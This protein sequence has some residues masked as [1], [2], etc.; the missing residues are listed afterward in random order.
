MTIQYPD[1]GAQ[2]AGLRHSVVLLDAGA[3][4]QPLDETVWLQAGCQLRRVRSL[5]ELGA[6]LQDPAAAWPDAVVLVSDAPDGLDAMVQALRTLAPGSGK[7]LALM[8]LS[9]RDDLSVRLA[10]ARAGIRAFLHLPVSAGQVRTALGQLAQDAGDE[11]LRVLVV[12]DDALMVDLHAAMLRSAGI[13]VQTLTQPLKLLETLDAFDPDVVVLDVYMPEAS[14]P[15]LAA[16]L[17]ERALQLGLDLPILFLSPE[18]DEQIQMQA[19]Q[20]GG[21][22]FLLKPVSAAHLVAAVT[23]RA[24]RARR[25]NQ[26]QRQLRYALH[27]R[28]REHQALDQHAIVSIADVHGNIVYAND[29]FC[30]ISGYDR[31]DLIGQNHRIVKSAEHAPQFYREIW[32]TI[33]AGRI[34]HGELCNRR[35]DGGLYWVESTIVPLLDESGLPH[36][37]VSIRTD[38]T[39]VKQDEAVLR[40]LVERTVA[41]SGDDFFQATVGGLAQSLGVRM[42]FVAVREPHDPGACRTL[43]LWDH[44]G[45]AENFSYPL[46]GAPCENVLAHGVSVY[47]DEVAQLFPQDRWLADNGF[48]SYVGI[49]LLDSHGALLG[50]MGILDEQPLADSDRIVTYLHLFAQR[51]AS[52]LERRHNDQMLQAH[53]E[54]LRRGQLF[55]NIGTWEWNIQTGEL[56]WTERIA[57]LFGYPQGDLET[58]YENFLK[59]V[60]PDDRQSVI[61]AVNACIERDVPYEIEHRV[62]W[63]DGTERWLLERGAVLRDAQGR[64]LQMLGVVQDID[65]RR[66]A[67]QALRESTQLLNEAQALAQVGSWR[68]D[69]AT[70]E[71]IWS[72]ELHRMYGSDPALPPPPYTEHHKLFTP[73]SWE[74]LAAALART[75]ESGIP[76]E[77]ELETVRHDGSS[78]W[79]WVRGERVHDE[80]GKVV[81]LRGMAQEITERKRAELALLESQSKLRGLFDLSPLGIALADL[82]G[83][84]LEFNEAFRVICGYPEE[85]LLALDYWALTP[86]KYEDSEKKQLATLHATGRYGPYE[87]EYRRKDGTL[88]PIRLNGLLIR[89]RLGN[90]AIWSIVEDIS[91]RKQVERDMIAAREAAERANQAKSEFLSSMSHELRTPMNAILG[92]G[93]LLEY[94]ETLS[95]DNLDNVREILKGGNHLLELINEVLDLARV[96][97][98]QIVLS[99]ETV[100]LKSAMDECLVL[101]GN[102]A[103][104]RGITL[105]NVCPSG[106]LVRADRTRLKQVLL[107]LLSNAIKYN[108]EGGNVRIDV[109]ATTPDRLRVRVCD[110][111]HGIA[112][113][114]LQALFEPFNRLDADKSGIEGAGIGLTITKRLVGMMD[115]TMGVESE[116]GVGSCF[117]FELPLESLAIPDGDE[118]LLGDSRLAASLQ[119]SQAQTHTV[120]YIE[121]NPANL[122][123]VSQILA[124]RS[125][126]HLLMAHSPGLGIEL[127]LAQRPELILLD[128]NL[129]EMDGYQVLQVL[130][131]DARLADVPVVAITANA[132][133]RDVERGMA[134]G[135]AGYLTKPLD[136]PLF[137]ATLDRLLSTGVE[138]SE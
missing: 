134:A 70:N 66:R 107:N 123:L 90:P 40:T 15:E 39:R 119:P 113:Q 99:L 132:M 110:T 61:D 69:V 3:G 102:L 49:P 81:A 82:D 73:V 115:G 118:V 126:V 84:Y 128:I 14:G 65:D 8:L 88:V 1:H 6:L 93:Q 138:P 85:E 43:A 50:H 57:P 9:S 23:M 34:W 101:V 35:K 89:D 31:A 116:V 112:Q 37:Y 60:H 98:G 59:A 22:D 80:H 56:F 131:A 117:W 20:S 137:L 87:K 103:D 52:E 129:P 63:P 125:H 86:K 55:A 108:R 75:V 104:R 106:C 25:N 79:M 135:F 36:Q 32:A 97:S 19:L 64:P 11:G 53:K 68:L 120:L 16:V 45:P 72:H 127:A 77:L 136:I 76:Y 29:K 83:R 62:V 24:R 54:R 28:E 48:K 95:E 94:D 67:A 111:G 96:E 42:A 47:A 133:P 17:R 12:D 46:A 91:D 44:D 4:P 130:R 114:H 38:I 2:S 58:S 30:A 51:V 7:A 13:S 18:T 109:Q 26:R 78:G 41:A 71:V 121:D 10:A 74:R 33:S 122:R 5:D 100:E 105:R 124:R 92:F 27:E 21:D